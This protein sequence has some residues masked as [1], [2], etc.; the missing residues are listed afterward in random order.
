MFPDTPHEIGPLSG[1]QQVLTLTDTPTGIGTNGITLDPPDDMKVE[2]QIKVLDH[3]QRWIREGTEASFTLK[4]FNQPHKFLTLNGANLEL[5]DT[6]K[7]ILSF[8]IS[9]MCIMKYDTK[10]NRYYLFQVNCG[11]WMTTL[12]CVLKCFQM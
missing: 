3:S 7:F 2:L 1:T 9:F 8:M 10:S 11:Q 6:S 5:S 12:K 4:T